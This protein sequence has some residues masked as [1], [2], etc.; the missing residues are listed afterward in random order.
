MSL[1]THHI[2]PE[3]E[4]YC[5]WMDAGV[6]D[7]KLCNCGFTCEECSFDA[8][9]RVRKES[10]SPGAASPE[11]VHPAGQ[12]GRTIGSSTAADAHCATA[13]ENVLGS[14]DRQP[15]PDDRLYSQHHTWAKADAEGSYV[16]GI[17]H[18]IGTMLGAAQSVAFS[19]PPAHIKASEPYAWIVANGETLAVCS[20]I[21]GTIIENNTALADRSAVIHADP[22]GKGWIARLRPDE[23]TSAE[24]LRAC[25]EMAGVMKDDR[26]RYERSIQSELHRMQT[27]LAGTMYDGGTVLENFEDILGTKKYYEILERFL[28]P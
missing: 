26:V 11:R 8:Q 1:S 25:D 14:I 27:Q 13:L 22:Y 4:R 5:I 12:Q 16:I 6:V 17:D 24:M 9:L 7:Y 10:L 2:I 21:S 18:F 3:G 15:L 23:H 20:P 28:R 19:V